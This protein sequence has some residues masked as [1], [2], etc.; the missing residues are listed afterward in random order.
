MSENDDVFFRRDDGTVG[1]S[2]AWILPRWR[3]GLERTEVEKF[4]GRAQERG[5][6]VE[7]DVL[8][9]LVVQREWEE[10]VAYVNELEGRQLAKLFGVEEEWEL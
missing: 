5:V 1:V 7:G 9:A 10:E 4:L 3:E 8:M 2:E 6:M